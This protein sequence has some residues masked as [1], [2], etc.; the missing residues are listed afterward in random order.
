MYRMYF[1]QVNHSEIV[2]FKYNVLYH[3]DIKDTVICYIIIIPD[4]FT[5]I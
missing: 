5:V 2:Y 1:L 4:D 3:I